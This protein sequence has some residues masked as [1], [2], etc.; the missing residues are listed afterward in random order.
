VVSDKIEIVT[1]SPVRQPLNFES[2]DEVLGMLRAHGHRISSSRRLVLEALFDAD[3]PVS[4][5]RIAEGLGGKRTK[6]ELTSVYRTLERLEELGV[7][8][9]V[10]IGHGPGLYA[11]VGHGEHAYLACENCHRIKAVEVDE[12]D[13]VSGEIRERFGYD[14]RFTH[15]AILGLCAD[16]SDGPGAH[17][18]KH[19]HSHSHGDFIHSHPHKESRAHAHRH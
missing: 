9:H 1:T 11:L 6:A 8:R 16:C 5:E 3:G 15:F 18:E 19:E 17:S 14:A 10:H 7:V 13:S 12:L 2:I 4:A